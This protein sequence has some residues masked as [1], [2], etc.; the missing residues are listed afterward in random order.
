MYASRQNDIQL[1]DNGRHAEMDLLNSRIVGLFLESLVCGI[2]MVAYSIG[3]WTLLRGD[4]RVSLSR[5]NKLLLGVNTLM[6]A[7]AVAHLCLTLQTTLYGFVV[8]GDTRQTAYDAL[9]DDSIFFSP[10]NEV[11]FYLYVTQTMIGD[12]FMNSRERLRQGLIM[13]R[14][15]RLKSSEA[16]EHWGW[17][18]RAI[19]NFVRYRRVFEAIVQSAAIYSAASISLLVTLFISH[20]V[21]FYACLS[22]FPP[23][24]I[25]RNSATSDVRTSRMSTVIPLSSGGRGEFYSAVEREPSPGP[26]PTYVSKVSQSQRTRKGLGAASTADMTLVDNDIDISRIVHLSAASTV[27]DV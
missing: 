1:D 12:G 11:Q 17:H 13:W 5:R 2:F 10:E 6:L 23:L 20:N 18:S 24:I 26:P 22:V 19:F 9:F 25:G 16:Q 4:Q 7:L 15:L 3:T 27:A 14:V 8:K 21:G